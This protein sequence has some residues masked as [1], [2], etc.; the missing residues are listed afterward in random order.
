MALFD[1]LVRLERGSKRLLLTLS[2]AGSAASGTAGLVWAFHVWPRTEQTSLDVLIVVGVCL[3]ALVGPFVG[4]WLVARVVLWIADGFARPAEEMVRSA[5]ADESRAPEAA[6]AEGKGSNALR[7]V[8]WIALAASF[9]RGLPVFDA[10]GSFGLD[11]I[12]AGLCFATAL[13][14]AVLMFCLD[15]RRHRS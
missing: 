6:E 3:A 9:L 4:F 2:L 1:R 7:V 10:G 13:L 15:V 11:G 5:T 8:I 12:G 14:G